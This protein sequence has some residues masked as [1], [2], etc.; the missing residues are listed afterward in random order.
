MES[1]FID[2]NLQKM[3][4]CRHF[5][6]NPSTDDVPKGPPIKEVAKFCHF[7][8]SSPHV[9]KIWP[10]TGK[11]NTGVRICQPLVRTSFMDDR[12]SKRDTQSLLYSLSLT[13]TRR[14]M[15]DHLYLSQQFTVPTRQ[16]ETRRRRGVHCT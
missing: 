7:L 10:F 11:I 4:G 5:C 16:H 15:P 12:F 3:I 9:R 6:P 8:L 1:V 2:H 13:L 14:Y